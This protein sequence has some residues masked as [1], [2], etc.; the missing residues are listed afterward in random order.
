MT[1]AHLRLLETTD[2]HMHLL[3]YDYLTQT[4]SRSIG[5]TNLT[6][7]IQD[8][9]D[10]ADLTLLFDNGDFLQ[11]NPLAEHIAAH[12]PAGQVHPVIKTL[13]ALGYD[14]LTLGNHE[15]DYGLDF[16][17]RV[18]AD[19]TIP[20]VCA[21]VRTG[22]QQTLYPAWTVL[23][24]NLPCADGESR[25]IRIGVIGFVTPQIVDWDAH[26]LNGQVRTDDII[27]AARTFLPQMRRAGVDVTVALCHSGISRRPYRDRMENAALHLAA[28]PGIDVVMAGH[29]HDRFPSP[30][31]EAI[32]DVNVAAG[33]LHG[34]PAVMAGSFGATLGV[35]DLQMVFDDDGWQVLDHEVSLRDAE[36]TATEAPDDCLAGPTLTRAHEA[37]LAHLRAPVTASPRRLT[38]Y[39]AALGHDDTSHLMAA[40]MRDAV[41]EG[42]Q[43]T[44][45]ADLPLL[46]ATAPF[47]GGG[48]GGAR[49][50]VDL[51]A[52][53][54][55]LADIAA[56]TPFNNPVC[57]ILRRGW[58]IRHWLE[59]TSAFFATAADGSDPLPLLNPQVAPYHFDTLHG[60]RYR[61][62]LRVPPRQDI[63]GTGFARRVRDL[64]LNGRAL[65]DDGLF[66]VATSSYRAYGGGGQISSAAEDVVFTTQN[67]FTD[68]LAGHL[69]AKGV[70]PTTSNPPWSFVP[71]VGG[72][73]TFA[74]APKVVEVLDD[75]QFNGTLAPGAL[76]GDGLQN[77]TLRF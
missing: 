29:T 48:H 47:R 53:E 67:G 70:P 66:V 55:T 27:A 43:G 35:I 24:R 15:F 54:L 45:Y 77:F 76:R 11:G 10:G 12:L 21:N 64:T 34:K 4:A 51:P 61:I 36:D 30:Q 17:H 49:N 39:L 46:V 38:S 19:T 5:L 58:Q 28:L 9:R 75:H 68:L 13:E 16:L 57:A 52:R 63:P 20:V 50:Y 6:P 25:E 72:A 26:H 60:L 8:A 31:F 33:T 74:T 22:P 40:A 2:L 7:L 65:E 14:A 73:L 1:T 71:W 42:L 41:T 32:D 56:I 69:K 23:T 18:L 59:Q 37:T 62:D 44:H 3:G